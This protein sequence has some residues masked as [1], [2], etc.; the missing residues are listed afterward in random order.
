MHFLSWDCYS[1][2][3]TFSRHLII[4]HHQELRYLIECYLKKKQYLQL[5]LFFGLRKHKICQRNL[6]NVLIRSLLHFYCY[7]LFRLLLLFYKVY[8]ILLIRYS[9]CIVRNKLQHQ[10]VLEWSFR[11]IDSQK[12]LLEY[13]FVEKKRKYV[14][15]VDVA[16]NVFMFSVA[17]AIS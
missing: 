15:T 10:Y 1:N 12:N 16:I 2:R 7:G 13:I 17:T 6:P 3:R 5:C 4:L 14:F 8:E 11:K 9:V